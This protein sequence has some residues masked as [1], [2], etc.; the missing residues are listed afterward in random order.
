MSTNR[1]TGRPGP[2][3]TETGRPV[4]ARNMARLRSAAAPTERHKETRSTV[5]ADW[6]V[7]GVPRTQGSKNVARGG[8]V[9]DKPADRA[10]RT[11]VQCEL[12]DLA[13]GLAGDC[14]GWVW[15]EPVEVGALFVFPRPKSTAGWRVHASTAPDLDK[16]CRSLGDA[17]SLPVDGVSGSLFPTRPL[18]DDRRIVRWVAE[19]QWTEPGGEGIRVRV[20]PLGLLERAERHPHAAARDAAAAELGL[21][22]GD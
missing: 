12:A 20:S 11:H 5:S 6:W 13:Y 16:L 2:T 7:S 21:R 1:A 3:P 4:T 18:R 19:K 14:G 9:F 17:M 8:W 22:D 10:W 15:D